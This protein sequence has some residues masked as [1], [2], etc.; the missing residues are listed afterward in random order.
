MSVQSSKVNLFAALSPR[1]R[2][3]PDFTCTSDF[4]CTS[5]VPAEREFNDTPRVAEILLR[6]LGFK[7]E[8]LNPKPQTPNPE[9][10]T[11]NPKP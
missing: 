3:L 2:A 8:T 6:G 11:L 7:P 9:P 5:E 4:A 1:A 10:E